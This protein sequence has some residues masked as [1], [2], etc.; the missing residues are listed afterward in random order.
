[1]SSDDHDTSFRS[2]TIAVMIST[3]SILQEISAMT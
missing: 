2:T 3:Y 1:L